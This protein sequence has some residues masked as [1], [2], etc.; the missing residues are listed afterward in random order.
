MNPP[1]KRWVGGGWSLPLR[2]QRSAAVQHKTGRGFSFKMG[3][4]VGLASIKLIETPVWIHKMILNWFRWLIQ[5][6]SLWYFWAIANY[7][8][9]FDLV[10][11][12]W[13]H[14]R[15]QVLLSSASSNCT[16]PPLEDLLLRLHL[17]SSNAT[18]LF[19]VQARTQPHCGR[20]RQDGRLVWIRL[21]LSWRRFFKVSM[22]FFSYDFWDIV[23]SIFVYGVLWEYSA[24][25]EYSQIWG[26]STLA[27]VHF[28]NRW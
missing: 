9:L 15:L 4:L 14:V 22:S 6:S 5:E 16:S 25:C 19:R 11:L 20:S 1:P 17:L 21:Y 3:F 2:A 12:C 7:L 26:I 23:Q 28:G 27:W 8:I 13:T 18:F 24:D 10:G